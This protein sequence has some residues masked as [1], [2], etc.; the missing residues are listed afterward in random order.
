MQT[1]IILVKTGEVSFFPRN[2]SEL[3]QTNTVTNS[4]NY[5]YYDYYDYYYYYYYY[6]YSQSPQCGLQKFSDT[7]FLCHD[8]MWSHMCFSRILEVVLNTIFW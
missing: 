8:V 3:V 1:P 6:Y 7:F 2:I 5:D 4:R